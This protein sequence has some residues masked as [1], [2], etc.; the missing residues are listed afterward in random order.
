MPAAGASSGFPKRLHIVTSQVDQ[1]RKLLPTVIG[2]NPF[3]SAKFEAAG[4]SYKIRDLGEFIE[5]VPFTTKAEISTDQIANPPYGS[6]LTFPLSAYSRCHQ[7]SGTSGAPIRWLDTPESWDWVLRN[8]QTVYAAAGVTREDVIFCPF[9]FGP[10]LGFWAAFEAGARSGALTLPGGG[11]SSAM[12]LR[13]IFDH[14]A[15]VLCA[16]PTYAMRLAE[17]AAQEGFDLAQ[18]PVKTI[19]VAG[20]PGGSIPATRARL[21]KLW[22]GARIFDHHGMTEIGPVTF[23]C[24]ARPG[25]LHVIETS[26]IA[27]II[28]PVTGAH[29]EPGDVGELVLTSLGRIGSPLLR[30]RT[31]DLVRSAHTG[32][33]DCGR[34]DMVLEGGILGRSDDM[35]VVRGVNVYP[36][37]VEDIVRGVGG[38]VEFQVNVTGGNGLA[39]MAVEA[40]FDGAIERPEVQARELEAAFMQSLALRVPVSVA[41]PGSLSRVEGKA[42]RWIRSA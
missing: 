37:A 25:V 22:P 13:V 30:Y 12:R 27:E 17:V 21:E 41:V 23:E 29:V 7:T 10:F 20:E 32:Y 34:H 8:W 11:M 1:L 26:Y 5:L 35:V 33:C 3:Y 15:T 42:R 9:S 14:R 40:E 16:T 31:G 19:I 6:N 38:I 39:E 28:N 24:P 4:I 18:S 36:S 2:N